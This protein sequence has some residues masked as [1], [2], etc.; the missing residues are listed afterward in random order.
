MLLLL[1]TG[2]SVTVQQTPDMGSKM[3]FSRGGDDQNAASDLSAVASHPRSS[4]SDCTQ[5]VSEEGPFVAILL[6]VCYVSKL[7]VIECPL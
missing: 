5:V 4:S 2:V 6:Q 1:V 3:S 7:T